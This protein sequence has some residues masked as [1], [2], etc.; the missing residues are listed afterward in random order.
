MELG[1]AGRVTGEKQLEEPGGEGPLRHMLPR[2]EL[3]SF[4]EAAAAARRWREG[5]ANH[6]DG[7]GQQAAEATYSGCL[8]RR[9]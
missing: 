8:W 5:A 2:F 1:R 6:Q 7:G 4:L 3:V 9:T